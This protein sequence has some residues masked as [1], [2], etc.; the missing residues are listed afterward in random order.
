MRFDT[1]YFDE[2]RYGNMVYSVNSFNNLTPE[3]ELNQ[4]EE[5]EIDRTY[6]RFERCEY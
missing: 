5:D 1:E 4:A 3:D 6:N 2:Q